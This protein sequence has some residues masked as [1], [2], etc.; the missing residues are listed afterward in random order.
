M[1]FDK[2]ILSLRGAKLSSPNLNEGIQAETRPM[3]AKNETVTIGKRRIAISNLNKLLY[4]GE[5]FT[6]AKVIDYYIRM[7]PYLLPHLKH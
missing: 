6:K 1:M 4:P 3:A 7:A 5:K 2:L